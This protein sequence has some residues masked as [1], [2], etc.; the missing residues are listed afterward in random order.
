MAPIWAAGPAL[1]RATQG[2]RI[3]LRLGHAPRLHGEEKAD[4]RTLPAAMAHTSAHGFGE[5]TTPMD[6]EFFCS[7][8]HIR[9]KISYM[10]L[11][12]HPSSDSIKYIRPN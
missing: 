9:S 10:V 2:H 12:N 3:S 7:L 1:L 6:W 8:L 4:P 11:I 5:A